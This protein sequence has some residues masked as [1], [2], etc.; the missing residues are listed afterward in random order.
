VARV[1]NVAGDIHIV[2]TVFYGASIGDQKAEIGGD[3]HR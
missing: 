2:P 1:A 3:N